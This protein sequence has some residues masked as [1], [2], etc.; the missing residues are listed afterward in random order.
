M[1]CWDLGSDAFRIVNSM[2][3]RFG[4]VLDG[5]KKASFGCRIPVVAYD[6]HGL[7]TDLRQTYRGAKDH[8]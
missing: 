6:R 5:I 2:L 7:G 3:W 4:P 8:L 1:V